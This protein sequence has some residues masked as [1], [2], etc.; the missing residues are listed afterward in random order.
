VRILLLYAFHVNEL[1]FFFFN[2]SQRSF[3]VISYGVV[4][5]KNSN[6]TLVSWTK[7]C[8]PISKGG[9]AFKIYEF[10]PCSFGKYLWRYG[11]ERAACWMPNLAAYG[12]DG[13]LTSQLV[14][15]G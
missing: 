10:Q 14:C 13:V 3:I 4:L 5:V 11:L 15:M 12:V 9:W 2:K 6:F 7:V 1:F 8:S